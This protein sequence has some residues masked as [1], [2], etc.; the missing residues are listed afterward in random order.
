MWVCGM[1][2][3]MDAV[4]SVPSLPSVV[5]VVVVGRRLG[6]MLGRRVV[7]ARRTRRGG[8]LCGR[9]GAAYRMYGLCFVDGSRGY[10]EGR[11]RVP[12]VVWWVT[13]DVGRD[14]EAAGLVL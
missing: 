6:G 14:D 2:C 13:S 12:F 10:L 5:V 9:H 3:V 1:V 4:P 7:C 8:N 11:R